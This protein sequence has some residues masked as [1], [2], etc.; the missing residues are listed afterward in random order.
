[1]LPIRL[2]MAGELVK[3]YHTPLRKACHRLSPLRRLILVQMR[4]MRV[5]RVSVPLF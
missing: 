3:Q 2:V 1:M 5:M 4:V